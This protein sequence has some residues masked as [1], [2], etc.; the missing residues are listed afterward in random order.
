V[1]IQRLGVSTPQQTVAAGGVAG[2]WLLDQFSGT[3][4]ERM[5]AALTAWAASATGGTIMLG[6]RSH[7]MA[8]PWQPMASLFNTGGTAY[9]Q[10]PLRITGQG[11]GANGLWQSFTGATVVNLTWNGT[12]PA[13]ID[14][15]GYGVL[16]IDRIQFTDTSGSTKPFLQSTNTTVHIHD[17][18][19]TG[20]KTGTACDQDAVILGGTD[21]IG[22][23]NATSA[24]GGYGSYVNN[25]FFSGIRRCVVLQNW[26]NSNVIR[27]NTVSASCGAATAG[28]AP[29]E[30]D[31]GGTGSI[32][33]H[34]CMGNFISG[35]LLEIA[36]Y[37]HGIILRNN[38]R[39]NAL[40]G[41]SFWD[42]TKPPTGT[43]TYDVGCD[44]TCS[45]NGLDTAGYS[46][47][48][49]IDPAWV[50]N[51]NSL[52]GPY[53]STAQ[54]P[55]TRDRYGKLF[56]ATFRI[57]AGITDTYGFA[58]TTGQPWSAA[59]FTQKAT[60]GP[61]GGAGPTIQSNTGRLTTNIAGG[62]SSADISRMHAVASTSATTDC[63]QLVKFRVSNTAVMSPSVF[64]RRD[65]SN[66]GVEAVFL[67]RT[68]LRLR[69]ITAGSFTTLATAT[70][71]ITAGTWY[72]ARVRVS[73]DSIGARFWQ[74][75]SFEPTSWDAVAATGVTHAA[76]E[77]GVGILGGTTA[78]PSG[79][80]YVEFSDYELVTSAPAFVTGSR[81]SGAAGA[82][83]LSYLDAVGLITNASSA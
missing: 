11:G 50:A 7:S 81:S 51:D 19:F 66:N 35:N 15:R 76:G 12:G 58:G 32:D 42:P 23:R 16:E 30:L 44:T 29:I 45:E 49:A 20:S 54:A 2:L 73:G 70:I 10:K 71:S 25:N 69:R 63:D 38:A 17:C 8:L 65:T 21:T 43:Y 64:A 67:T 5:A 37:S 62:S 13:K 14:T 31:S 74:D 53:S 48:A 52:S 82:T 24:F 3:D 18:A 80:D 41:N 77:C 59:R 4:D 75:G 61:S 68:E 28:I 27:D 39:R 83:L 79:T 36:N 72:W 56:G 33:D 46:L 22:S 26:S 1:S 47:D 60:P 34:H 40:A 55:V 78:A 57:G 9:T 6:A